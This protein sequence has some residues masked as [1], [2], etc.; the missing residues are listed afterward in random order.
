MEVVS[1]A[2]GIRIAVVLYAF[3]G[4]F[5]LV[6]SVCFVPRCPEARSFDE[7]LGQPLGLKPLAPI[8][9]RIRYGSQSPAPTAITC[10][11][12][13]LLRLAES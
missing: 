11:R 7:K 12:H 6:E 5:E 8:A 10:L 1:L 13:D 4:R 2:Y 3:C 9:P